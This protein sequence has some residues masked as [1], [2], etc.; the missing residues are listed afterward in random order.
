MMK[1]SSILLAL[2][3]SLALSGCIS[4][5]A[6]PPP[7]LLRLTPAQEN[8][9]GPA[10]SAAAGQAVTVAIPIVGQELMTQRVPVHSGANQVAYLKD[11]QWVDM[12]NA[13][14]ARLV[15]ETISVR[16]GRVV[17]D[18]RQFSLDPGVKLTGTLQSFGLD[19]DKMEA[20]VVYDAMVARGGGRVET[21]RFSARSPVAVVDGPSA[22]AALNQ[23]ANQVAADVAA[24]VG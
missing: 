1:S 13:L 19:A 18:P 14:F 11:A 7:F 24:W 5:G 12:P 8:A 20:V 15:A 17:L 3:A 4:F 10:R 6:K 2:G 23:A 9:A 22:A 21:R 16:T